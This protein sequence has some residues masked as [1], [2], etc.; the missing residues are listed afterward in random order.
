SA[1]RKLAPNH[2]RL[3]SCRRPLE[4][5]LEKQS[6]GILTMPGRTYIVK[7]GD[8]LS[9]IASRYGTS[10]NKLVRINHLPDPDKLQ[11]G[12]HL[13]LADT[14]VRCVKPLFLDA[15]YNP[16]KGLQYRMECG[17]A[18][19]HG[20]SGS[21]GEGTAHLITTLADTVVG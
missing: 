18:V 17:T 15:A 14:T 13:R 4:P 7:A 10:V 5:A 1:C 3:A 12:Q 11:V 2:E 6:K 8:T 9:T 16:L 19:V 20:T 21:N